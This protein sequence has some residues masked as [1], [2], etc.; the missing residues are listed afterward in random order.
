MCL[1]AE[2]GADAI[3]IF[4]TAVGELGYLDFKN[5]TLPKLR[6]I[7]SEFKKVHPNTKI[8]YYSRNTHMRYLEAIDDKNI[9]VLG[10]DWR[11]D[12]SE[13]INTFGKDYY[14][15]GNFDP[16][17]LHISWDQL[18]NNLSDW[19]EYLL[20]KNIDQSKW[21]AGLG[22]GVLQHTPQINVKNTVQFIHDNFRY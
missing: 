1:Q 10:V 22:H 18:K 5:E 13:V 6:E 21:I 2:G 3:C 12:L 11:H 9:D 20:K 8:V 7:T 17:W 15:Q 14:I 19:Y 16:C 4:D